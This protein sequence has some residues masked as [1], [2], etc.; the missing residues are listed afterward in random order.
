MTNP[1]VIRILFPPRKYSERTV[2]V[3]QIRKQ[4]PELQRRRLIR[5]LLGAA[6]ALWIAFSQ[7]GNVRAQEPAAA[8]ADQAAMSQRLHDEFKAAGAGDVT[9]LVILKNQVDLAAVAA[10]AGTT[11]ERAAVLYPQLTSLASASQASLRAFLDTQDVPWRAYY[12]VNMIEVTGDSALADALRSRPEVDRLA[13]NPPVAGVQDAATLR[14]ISPWPVSWQVVD[15]QQA[16]ATSARPWGLDY[17]KAPQVW[18]MGIQGAGIV[19]ASQDTG[20]EWDHPA[21]KARY[22]GWDAGSSTASHVYN[23]LDAFGVDSTRQFRCAGEAAT[24]AQI[25]CDDHGHGTHT[26]GTMLGD[27]TTMSDTVIGMAPE[28]EWIGCRNMAGGVGTPASYAACFEFFLAPYPQGGDPFVDGKPEFAPHIINNS[29]GCP[30]SE[31][32]DDPNILKQVVETSRA[33][34]Q[35]VAASAGNTGNGCSTVQDPI[36]IY[37]AVFTVG[38]FGEGGGMAGFS[39]RGPVTIDGSGRLKPD[40][41]APGVGVRSATRGGGMSLLSGTSMASPHIAG[42][43]ALLWSAFPELNGDVDATEGI[44]R[45]SATGVPTDTCG[46]PNLFVSPNALFGAGRLDVQR[47][48]VRAVLRRGPSLDVTVIDPLGEPVPGVE[49]RVKNVLTSSAVTA[50]TDESGAASFPIVFTLDW[51]GARSI[52]YT[53]A[54]GV[55]TADIWIGLPNQQRMPILFRTDAAASH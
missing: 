16:Q 45:Q 27:A 2:I 11:Q 13:A 48:V 53:V 35:F 4:Q 29:W 23:W 26:V 30:P 46:N 1:K 21:L 14:S 19:V 41:A 32:C 8:G 47:A 43:V 38:A 24:N 55:D 31:G 39:S 42:A 5:L 12:I 15:A 3:P 17:V 50:V 51:S 36:A 25:P 9:F 40:I 28:A 20:V 33:A 44:L 49:V 22:R 52:I 34:G 7:G 54:P 10:V 6:L 18:E 37:D